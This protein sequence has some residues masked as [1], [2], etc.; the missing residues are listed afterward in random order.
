MK[1]ITNAQRERLLAN[2]RT[3]ESVPPVVKWFDPC[4]SAT[5]LICKLDPEDENRAFGLCDLGLGFP[6]VGWVSVSEVEALRGPLGLPMERDVMFTAS[7]P[8]RDYTQAA[9]AVGHIVDTLPDQ[10][11]EERPAYS[12]AATATAL[13]GRQELLNWAVAVSEV[14]DELDR[15]AKICDALAM[16]KGWENAMLDARDRIQRQHDRLNT[17]WARSQLQHGK[18]GSRSDLDDDDTDEGVL[19]AINGGWILQRS[20]S[21][22][23]DDKFRKVV[24]RMPTPQS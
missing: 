2:G 9:L 3:D 7:R 4:G 22:A 10:V 16:V 17:I 1:L 15:Q 20:L 18:K 5:W 13:V 21:D 23:I 19:D 6:E 24:Q 8:L 14:M 11:A 12:A